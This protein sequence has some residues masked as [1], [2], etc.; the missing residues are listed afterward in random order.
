MRFHGFL[1]VAMTLFAVPLR[2]H[3]NPARQGL[4]A[5][6]L[7]HG[8][9]AAIAKYPVVTVKT[10]GIFQGYKDKPVF[11]HKSELTTNGAKQYRVEIRFEVNGV[12]MHVVN[13]FDGN[14]GWIKQSALP[15]SGAQV[16][17]TD[18]C[19][20]DQIASFHENGYINQLFTLVPMRGAEYTLSREGEPEGEQS[21][22]VGIRVFHA[23]Q[24]DVILYVD[25]D[26]H[27]LKKA[28]YRGKAGTDEERTVETRFGRYEKVQG[29]QMPTSWEEWLNG[30]CIWSHHVV[31]RV[32]TGV[33][34][35]DV[36]LID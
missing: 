17:K 15:L 26:T 23:N 13:A 3:E 7:A 28:I 22:V 33:P 12:K 16:V 21:T 8:G 29:V 24:R 5:A 34:A 35:P 36:F 4:D 10:E 19:T 30:Q 2:A 20:P 14:Q 6:I 9:E 18:R 31:E 32:F 11:F 27:L 1:I 25:K